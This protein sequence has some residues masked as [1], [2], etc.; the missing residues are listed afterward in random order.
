VFLSTVVRR[1]ARTLSFPGSLVAIPRRAGVPARLFAA[2]V[3]VLVCGIALQ[4]MRVMVQITTG[5][6]LPR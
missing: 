3:L 1:E 6:V 2:V 5:S 4:M